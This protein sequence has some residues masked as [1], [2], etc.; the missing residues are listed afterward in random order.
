MTTVVNKTFSLTI[1]HINDLKELSNK[2]H[3]GYSKLF[4]A[5]IKYFKANPEEF[6]KIGDYLD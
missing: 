6:K 3:F 5:F 1:E 4:K 2:S